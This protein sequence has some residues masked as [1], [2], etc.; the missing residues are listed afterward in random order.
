MNNFKKSQKI[1]KTLQEKNK[2]KTQK[3]RRV[4]L[5]SRFPHHMLNE[6]INKLRPSYGKKKNVKF[7]D[8]KINHEKKEKI[9]DECMYPLLTCLTKGDHKKT[10]K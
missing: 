9:C 2:K 10:K 3:M 5:S 1:K 8:S 6:N 7:L 4:V